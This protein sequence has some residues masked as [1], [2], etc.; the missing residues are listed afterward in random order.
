MDFS[1]LK[2]EL[3]DFLGLIIPGLLTICEG[4]ITLKGVRATSGD[5]VTSTGEATRLRPLNL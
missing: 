5:P 1:K 4:W 2:L 3:Y